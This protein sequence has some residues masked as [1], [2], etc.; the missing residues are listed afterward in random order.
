[1]SV[2]DELRTRILEIVEQ[3]HDAQFVPVDFVNRALAPIAGTR[4]GIE[5]ALE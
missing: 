1:M 3:Y 5:T 2:P 4:H